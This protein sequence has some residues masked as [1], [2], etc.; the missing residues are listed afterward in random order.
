MSSSLFGKLSIET[1]A[2]SSAPALYET[3]AKRLY[4]AP[5]LCPTYIQKVDLVEGNWEEVG[6]VMNWHL[7]YEGKT[8]ISKEIYENIDDEKL[9][10]TFKVIGGLLSEAYKSFKFVFQAIPKKE[11]CLGRWSVEYEK[12]NAEIPDPKQMLQ[13]S[14]GLTKEIDDNLIMIKSKK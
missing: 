12:L 3:L 11:G 9:S 7:L 6:A 13:F 1:E 5:K 8:V 10:V 4:E 2:K 14:A